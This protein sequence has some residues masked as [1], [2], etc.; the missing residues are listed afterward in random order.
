MRASFRDPDAVDVEVNSDKGNEKE[1]DFDQLDEENED[2]VTVIYITPAPLL[3]T[4]SKPTV[5][6]SPSTTTLPP[7]TTVS[8]SDLPE[9]STPAPDYFINDN[10]PGIFDLGDIVIPHRL[11]HD[12][13][14]K[15]T[16]ATPEIIEGSGKIDQID[17]E[18]YSTDGDII[19]STTPSQPEKVESDVPQES[20]EEE[21]ETLIVSKILQGSQEANE[22][23]DSDMENT[24]ESTTSKSSRI[25]MGLFME[26]Y[27]EDDY[28]FDNSTFLNE[29]YTFDG[30]FLESN[31]TEDN[32]SFIL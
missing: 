23:Q 5:T 7:V 4:L 30:I 28:S 11:R 2:E 18:D 3:N 17:D 24:E 15:T 22:T 6:E 31:E 26:D 29:T 16:I 8:G 13:S 9:S 14:H 21:K 20:S 19:Y 1:K 10:I 25:P 32:G 27:E 12:G